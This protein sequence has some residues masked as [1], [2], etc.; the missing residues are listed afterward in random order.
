MERV[1]AWL[2]R[3]YSALHGEIRLDVEH[4]P[5]LIISAACLWNFTKDETPPV[6]TGGD[7][8]GDERWMDVDEWPDRD[9]DR[10]EYGL[11]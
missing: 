2:K 6:A 10:D 3:R 5:A 4:I 9:F 7:E 8:P 1:I 11:F